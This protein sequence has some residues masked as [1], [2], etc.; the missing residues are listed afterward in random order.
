MKQTRNTIY[1]GLFVTTATAML[2]ILLLA[3]G[4][5]G[6]FTKL[7]TYSMYFNKSVKGLGVGSPVM[8][9]ACA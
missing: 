9:R 4:G 1:L 5:R 3:M 2:V 7:A 6:L 8:F